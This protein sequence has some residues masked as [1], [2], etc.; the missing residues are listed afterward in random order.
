MKRLT[1]REIKSSLIMIRVAI[2]NE[3]WELF[4]RYYPALKE[5]LR[6]NIV[7]RDVKNDLHI[8][9]EECLTIYCKYWK[10]NNVEKRDLVDKY[11]NLLLDITNE[12]EE[13]VLSFGLLKKDKS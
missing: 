4:D 6:R 8:L 13:K 3:N 5:I 10:T 7:T 2:S 12:Q 9:C 1:Y 11:Y